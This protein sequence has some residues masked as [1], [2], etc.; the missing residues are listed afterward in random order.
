VIGRAGLEPDDFWAAIAASLEEWDQGERQGLV[1]L[2]GYR[3]DFD[4]AA[5]RAAQLGVDL[6]VP[7]VTAFFSWPSCGTIQGYMA[8][9][10]SIEA[11]E[12]FIAE[13]LDN[14]VSRSG[15]E[16]VHLLAHSMGNRGLLRA[17]QRL[18]ARLSRHAGTPFGQII[19]AAPDIDTDVFTGLAELYPPSSQRTTLYASRA[20]RVID[21]S[22]RIHGYPRAG[23]TPPVTVVPGVDTVEV[24]RFNVFEL[25]GH[26]YYAEAEGLLH[27]I[28]DLIRWNAAPKDRQRLTSAQTAAGSV[29]WVMNA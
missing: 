18:A 29:Y 7:G 9:E 2:H 1:F 23:L 11:S 20:D 25:L 3:V 26:G 15:V 27:D 4:D 24:P 22:H 12:P 6:K 17:L 10:A 8:D 13:F 21:L 14:F 19:L 16:R 5:I 28:F